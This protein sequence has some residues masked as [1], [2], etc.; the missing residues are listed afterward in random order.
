[1]NKSNKNIIFLDKP[2]PEV[3]WLLPE[4]SH[5]ALYSK[6][7]QFWMLSSLTGLKKTVS[8]LGIKMQF[9]ILFKSIKYFDLLPI[10][11][12]FIDSDN[13]CFFAKMDKDEDGN[14][15]LDELF[16]TACLSQEGFAKI[17]AIKVID[18]FVEDIRCSSRK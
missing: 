4:M 10:R 15:S 11:K 13:M 6:L 7:Q 1:M 17:L 9:G 8:N 18:I 16:V 3:L 12:L 5:G 14:V 2:L